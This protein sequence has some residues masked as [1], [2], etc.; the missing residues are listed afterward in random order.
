MKTLIYVVIGFIVFFAIAGLSI[1]FIYAG[2]IPKLPDDLKLLASSAP[3]EIYSRDGEIITTL[4]GRSYI[5]IDRI[6]VDFQNAIIAAEDKRFYSHKGIDII[7]T[8]RSLWLNL[9]PGGSRPGGSTIT[10]QLAKN[11]FFAF[12][13]S[14][15]RKILEALASFAIEDRFNK[16][17]ILEAYCNLVYFGKF[18]YG[19]ENA[20]LTYFNK[21]AAD[22]ELHQA[23]LL[24]GLPNSPSRL[25]PFNSFEKAKKRQ[26]VILNRM[27]ANESISWLWVDSLY[28]LPVD[29][30]EKP[31]QI[32]KSSHPI[33]Y[34]ISL[35]SEKIGRYTV[36]YGGVQILTTIDP[37]LQTY[38]EQ[39]VASGVNDLEN[40]L[41]PLPE[42]DHTRLEGALV[43]IEVA[44]GQILAMVGSRNY[45]E[46][47]FNRAIHASRHPG[48]SFK[49]VVYLTALEQD[50][51]TPATVFIDEPITLPIDKKREY[52]PDNFSNSHIGPVTLKYGLMK[53]I[54]TIAAQLIYRV[55]PEAVVKTASRLGIRT[56]LKPHLSLSLGAQ[57]ITPLEM[58][59][60]YTTLARSGRSIETFL[61]SRIE[62][63]GRSM[64]F[65]SLPVSETR[66][67]H[68][69]VYILQDMM[70]DVI[71]GGTGQVLRRRGFRGTAIG[72]TGTSSDFKDSWFCGAT[73]TL[74][75]VVWIGYDDNRSM[76]NKNGIGVVGATG[77]APIWADFMIRATAGE[78]SR[79][80][81]RP[82][83][84]VTMFM[85]PITGEINHLPQKN[86][87]IS[88]VL[89]EKDV[90]ALL[91]KQQTETEADSV[92]TPDS[93][94]EF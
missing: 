29:L 76:I 6:S 41:K 68:E 30:L 28:N 81:R 72:K 74:A 7:A 35:A 32:Q 37:L 1:F 55:T 78:P 43:A 52:K 24:A 83:G 69:T 15:E 91:Q 44:T 86:N 4:G 85:D 87:W 14:W 19:I 70:K 58:A 34:A 12:H 73:P 80:F 89:L 57:G 65:E 94:P 39:A 63:R 75:V 51:L 79:N 42:N 22:L 77:A 23:A 5:S 49:P 40:R 27:A 62:G 25:N 50:S 84:V 16:K 48:S 26:K 61:V 59:R 64:M 31:G 93:L 54:N 53:S 10:Q 21:H 18:A 13:R 3:T 17:Q 20:S 67:A 71:E 2:R 45:S 46:S 8:V 66:F 90:K 9:V 36:N 92:F 56:S 38:A 60:M 33:D 88:V 47:T 11:M 82:L